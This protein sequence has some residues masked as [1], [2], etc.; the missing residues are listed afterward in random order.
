M[1]GNEKILENLE[2]R[3]RYYRIMIMEGNNFHDKSKV[4]HYHAK[5]EATEAI[6]ED[7]RFDRPLPWAYTNK[8]KEGPRK[9]PGYIIQKVPGKPCPKC[10]KLEFYTITESNPT[11][12]KKHSKCHS[13]GHGVIETKEKEDADTPNKG[14]SE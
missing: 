3:A 10:G 9:T 8:I 11:S 1:M 5:L 2:Q 12:I 7:I 13:C 14:K 4:N 6:I